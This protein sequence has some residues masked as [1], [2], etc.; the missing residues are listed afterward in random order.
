M[1]FRLVAQ[2]LFIFTL[3]IGMSLGAPHILP[4]K[5]VWFHKNDD[6]HVYPLSTLYQWEKAI[7]Q[8]D[9]VSSY[10]MRWVFPTTLDL[11]VSMKHPV[12]IQSNG[13][14]VADDISLFHLRNHPADLPELINVDQLHLPQAVKLLKS[15]QDLMPIKSILEYP[16]GAV[17]VKTAANQEMTF[18]SMHLPEG[19]IPVVNKMNPEGKWRCNF[20]HTKYASCLEGLSP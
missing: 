3:L 13:Q 6:A 8:W 2:Y 1:Y 12:A 17:L 16:S 5:Y 18:P 20:A 10:R 19:M 11:A 15:L 14:L 7:N 4:V 9:W